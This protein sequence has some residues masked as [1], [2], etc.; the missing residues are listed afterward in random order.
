[1]QNKICAST[2]ALAFCLGLSWDVYHVQDL[3]HKRHKNFAFLSSI[4]G[5]SSVWFFLFFFFNLK[6]AY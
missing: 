2:K 4:L 6:T 3:T 1:M 5:L